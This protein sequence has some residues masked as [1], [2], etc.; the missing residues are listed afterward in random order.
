MLGCDK[1]RS[2]DANPRLGRYC[3]L[4]PLN[5]RSP[6][7][8]QTLR[9]NSFCVRGPKLFNELGAEL[10]NFNGSLDAFKRRLDKYLENV[11]DKPYDPTEPQ[12]ADSNSLTDQI[13][14]VRSMSRSLPR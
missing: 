8:I 6:K 3:L 7:Y 5:N 4:P 2:T 12:M 9:E 1:I 14:C 11:P 13:K 10:R